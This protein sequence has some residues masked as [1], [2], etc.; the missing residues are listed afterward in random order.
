GGREGARVLMHRRLRHRGLRERGGEQGILAVPGPG[1]GLWR[2]RV[3]GRTG[4][5]VLL[6]LRGVTGLGVLLRVPRVRGVLGLVRGAVLA[7]RGRLLRGRGVAVA[8]RWRGAVPRP[9]PPGARPPD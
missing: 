8:L 3:L 4:R 2:R 7:G 1:V 6:L 5:A 9:R